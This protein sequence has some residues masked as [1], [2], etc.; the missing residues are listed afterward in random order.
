LN[1]DIDTIQLGRTDIRIPSM[2]I[3]AWAWGD[4]FFWAFR[5][6]YGDEEVR[7]A[8]FTSLEAGISLFDTAE[9]YGMGR[10]E[11]FL[12]KFAN[13]SSLPVV[14]ATKFFPYPWRFSKNSLINALKSSLKRL[15]LELVDL[16]QIHNPFSIV[17]VETWMEALGE[18]VKMGLTRAIGVSN[19][20]QE[21]MLRAYKTMEKQ[22][23]PLASNQVSYSLLDRKVE[24]NGLLKTCQELGITLIA[25]SPIAQGI[26]TGKYS[27]ENPLPGVRGRRYNR[28]FLAKI[29]PLISR[30]VEIGNQHGGKSSA[31]VALNWV[32]CKGAVPIP[33][34]KNSRQAQENIGA[35]GWR[36][37]EEEVA[38][39]DEASSI[40]L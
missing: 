36:L 9:V 28:A 39:L 24:L 31:Q 37:N 25:Y 30:M 4:R 26:L 16:Y 20:D 33:G 13:E 23:I 18:A 21:K 8:F 29:Q 27:P 6:D 15:D 12:G 7:A 1:L 11:R 17:P 34:A 38:S 22:G 19:Y 3:G 2:G 14:I 32:I 35:V 40:F 10:S 5:K